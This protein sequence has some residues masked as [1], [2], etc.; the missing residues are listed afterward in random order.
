MRKA[1]LSLL[2]VLLLFACSN[3]NSTIIP[4]KSSGTEVLESQIEKGDT[5]TVAFASVVSPQETRVKYDLLIN[6]LEEKLERPII[7]VQK[8]TYDEVNE[9][10][11]AGDVDIAFICSLSYV[12]G[13]EKNYLDGIAAP[14]VNGSN[15][16]RSY[17]ITHINSEIDT[18]EDLGGKRFAFADPFSYSGRLSVLNMLDERG[19]TT[20]FFDDLFYTYSHDYSV[21]AVA[22][23]AVDAAAVDSLLFDQLVKL[24][25]DDASLVKIIEYGKYAGTPPIVVSKKI[26]QQVKQKIKNVILGLK[27]DPIGRG[28]LQELKIDEYVEIDDEKY[29]PIKNMLHLLGDDNVED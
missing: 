11:E 10:V 21:S 24:N 23:G 27:D 13:K 28:I 9:M 22:R 5:I 1:G 19:L 3:S 18:F 6:Y 8:Q 16:Y 29:L 17:V 20:N 7:I 15:L 26:E 12:I 14:V 25:N 2:F 4:L